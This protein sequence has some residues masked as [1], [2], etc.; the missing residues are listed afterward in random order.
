MVNPIRVALFMQEE[1]GNIIS[2][3]RVPY[4]IF[5]K[6]SLSIYKE[7]EGRQ[8]LIKSF[9][10]TSNLVEPLSMSALTKVTN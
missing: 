8:I 6:F 10:S 5:M 2:N 7:N 9:T 4:N 1:F 3:M